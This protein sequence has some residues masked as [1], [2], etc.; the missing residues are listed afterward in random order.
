MHK[1]FC[2]MEVEEAVNIDVIMIVNKDMSYGK[3]DERAY[4][5]FTPNGTL[6]R[7]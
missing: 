5:P 4:E 3:N 2:S 1:S 7:R 6:S